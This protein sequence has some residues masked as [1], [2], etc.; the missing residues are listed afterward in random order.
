M[1]LCVYCPVEM[2]DIMIP[3]LLLIVDSVQLNF[4][5]SD[6][7]IVYLFNGQDILSF[8]SDDAVW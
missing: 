5:F 2:C 7:Q 4:P 3:D 6:R 1:R 8:D